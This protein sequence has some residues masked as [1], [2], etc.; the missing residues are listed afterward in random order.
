MTNLQHPIQMPSRCL[1]RYW[2]NRHCLQAFALGSILEVRVY[3]PD[4]RNDR[5]SSC[6]A[7]V[8]DFT[9]RLTLFQ[10]DSQC[11]AALLTGIIQSSAASIGILQRFNR[12]LFDGLPIIRVEVPV[13]RSVAADEKCAPYCAFISQCNRN[14]SLWLFYTADIFISPC[15]GQCIW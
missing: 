5:A 6:T 9:G 12:R 7:S 11:S 10:S 3:H 14:G 4:D 2:Q 1:R 13:S 8:P 15:T